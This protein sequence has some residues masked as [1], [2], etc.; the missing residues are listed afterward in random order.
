LEVA[1]FEEILTCQNFF[2][3]RPRPGQDPWP[4]G[5]FSNGKY[6]YGQDLNQCIDFS[7]QKMVLVGCDGANSFV[8][9]KILSSDVVKHEHVDYAV[10]MTG[11]SN[12]I[13]EFV[14]KYPT[15]DDYATANTTHIN[16]GHR[17]Y[18]QLDGSAYLGLRVSKTL[19]EAFLR[20]KNN[21]SAEEG[22]LPNPFTGDYS[23]MNIFPVVAQKTVTPAKVINDV[24]VLLCGD[25]CATT[26]FF[27]GIG[28]NNGI[29]VST[30]MSI[31]IAQY[32]NG[33]IS[34]DDVVNQ[35]EA[36]LPQIRM[37]IDEKVKQVVSSKPLDDAVEIIKRYQNF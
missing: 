24:P 36:S 6:F 33:N 19:Y 22:V 26:N 30:Q 2:I 7:S 5:N 31:L 1:L 16:Q 25:S 8:R 3:H 29:Q 32:L 10:V 37:R 34:S 15:K 12:R 27:T 20:A 18:P 13:D 17:F 28:V 35:F 4:E 21:G 9:R 11:R 14:S 23:S